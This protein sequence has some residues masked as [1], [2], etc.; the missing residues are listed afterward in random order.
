[1]TFEQI[2]E[3]LKYF[4]LVIPVVILLLVM[5]RCEVVKSGKLEKELQS[6]YNMMR[7]LHDSLHTVT[8]KNGEL[9][10]YKNA[11]QND[12]KSMKANYDLMTE[13]QKALY[14]ELK[15]NKKLITAMRADMTVRL[16][17]L[18]NN[19]QYTVNNDS[20]SVT[21]SD[22]TTDLKYNISVNGIKPIKPELVIND[23][24]LPNKQLVT[25]EFTKDG[26]VKV[27]IKNSNKFFKT[28][29]VDGY[30][31]PQVTEETVKP[32]KWKKIWGTTKKVALGVGIG[33]VT[34]V[35][36]IAAGG[37]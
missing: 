5:H 8:T 16:D 6:N 2:K 18:K 20:T 31:I 12:M 25:H 11:F 27:T 17:S 13:N 35:I 24:E 10:S 29:D 3:K 32:N 15:S 36:F 26:G 9:I 19:N 28:T 33:L 7:V 4:Y 23:L 1:M 21:F 37:N 14:N 30:I 22:S 34:A